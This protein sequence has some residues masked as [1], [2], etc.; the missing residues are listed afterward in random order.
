MPQVVIPEVSEK[1][2]PEP[3]P[4]PSLHGQVSDSFGH[5]VTFSIFIGTVYT[6][7]QSV[8]IMTSASSVNAVER[9][10]TPGAMTSTPLVETLITTRDRSL[11]TF[12][13]HF[14]SNETMSENSSSRDKFKNFITRTMSKLASHTILDMTHATAEHRPT[15]V[16]NN[17]NFTTHEKQETRKDKDWQVSVIIVSVL[18]VGMIVLVV[19]LYIRGYHRDRLATNRKLKVTFAASVPL[20]RV[21]DV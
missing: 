7:I 10:T 1:L 15:N 16:N 19:I 3:E 13:V 2:K 17:L 14:V 18:I 4:S 20:I 8:K 21:S 6:S 12:T 5:D 9:H 11:E